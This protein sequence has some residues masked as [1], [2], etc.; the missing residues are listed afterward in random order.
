[1]LRGGVGL[2]GLHVLVSSFNKKDRSPK[3]TLLTN[4]EK[5]VTQLFY[6]CC[7]YSANASWRAISTKAPG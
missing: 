4:E 2:L 3:E 6:D 5:G 7:R 1:M